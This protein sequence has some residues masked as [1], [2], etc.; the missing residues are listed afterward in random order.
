[1]THQPLGD[2]RPLAAPV[3]CQWCTAEVPYEFTPAGLGMPDDNNG[4]A[5]CSGTC[6]RKAY[7][8][9]ICQI[10]EHVLGPAAF[11]QLRNSAPRPLPPTALPKL[12]TRQNIQKAI[13]TVT[14][15]LLTDRISSKQASQLLYAIQTALGVLRTE[16]TK[17]WTPRPSSTAASAA[18]NSTSPE[19]NS[20]ASSSAPS[21]TT[22][23][24]RN[25]PSRCRHPRSS[26]TTHPTAH[27]QAKDSPQVSH[28]E[29]DHAD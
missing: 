11:E 22:A 13:A 25:S 6:C 14:A 24:R 2:P 20:T 17:P 5:Y 1:M 12:D 15:A 27:G 18:A 8:E 21:A 4:V 3:Y 29:P 10:V 26:A 9:G 28:S 19:P 7:A 23:P 16:R